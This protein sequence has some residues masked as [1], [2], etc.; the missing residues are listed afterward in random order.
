VSGSSGRA[1]PSN[2]RAQLGAAASRA[3]TSKGS[4]T[5][6]AGASTGQQEARL[7]AFPHYVT[8]IDDAS[9]HFL[10]LRSPEP[11]ARPLLLLHG[12]PGSF[13]EFLDVAEPLS[14]PAAYGGDPGDAFD[15][16]IPSIP[17]HGFSTI[18]EPGW[19]HGGI[20]QV[21]A[22]L[23]ERNGYERYRVQGGDIGAFQAPTLSSP[24]SPATQSRPP[25]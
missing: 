23:M 12:L 10:Y 21:F 17:G 13:V 2:S 7:N 8:E 25:T 18:G 11:E 4:S 15:L 9:V 14:D 19:T 6:G 5:T 20:A 16:V 24:R 22:T 1:G 3:T